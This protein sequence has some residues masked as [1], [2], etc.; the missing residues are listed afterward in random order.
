MKEKDWYR[1]KL[2]WLGVLQVVSATINV[3][4]GDSID[5]SR[6]DWEQFFCGVTTIFLRFVTSQPIK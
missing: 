3:Q 4:Q 6:V 5:F 1:S 2:L